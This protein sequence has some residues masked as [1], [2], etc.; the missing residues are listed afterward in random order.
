ML[1][2][3][4]NLCKKYYTLNKPKEIIVHYTGS[5]EG[6]AKAVSEYFRTSTVKA[7]AHYIVDATSIY[8]SVPE[9]RGAYHS[10][11]K[12]VNQSSI[13]IEICV[14]K[15]NRKHISASDNDWYFDYETLNNVL[16]LIWDIRKRYGN[17]PIRRHFDVNKKVCPAPWV[18][19]YPLYVDF[20]NHVNNHQYFGAHSNM[21]KGFLVR[22]NRTDLN[23]RKSASAISSCLGQI[24]VGVYTIIEVKNGWGKLASG[25]GWIKL[26]YTEEV[27]K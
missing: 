19:N 26:K 13:G 15:T 5:P 22:V 4:K 10:G 12:R 17:L 20:I 16:E 9:D 18:N 3:T 14:H 1:P 6:T 2:I 24:P 8:Q 27:K 11:N 23:I 21:G 7:S 25:A